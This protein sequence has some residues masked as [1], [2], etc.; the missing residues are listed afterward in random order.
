MALGGCDDQKR[1]PCVKELI[2]LPSAL[3]VLDSVIIAFVRAISRSCSI[4]LFWR[5]ACQA[6]KCTQYF[7]IHKSEVHAAA[8][9]LQQTWH[10]DITKQES[11]T[12]GAAWW[13]CMWFQENQLGSVQPRLESILSVVSCVNLDS[14]LHLPE[15]HSLLCEMGIV[16]LVLI[17]SHDHLGGCLQSMCVILGDHQPMQM[18]ATLRVLCNLG[19]GIQNANPPCHSSS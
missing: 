11:K 13:E 12:S 10:R 4:I 15:S 5:A 19:H 3:Q 14:S 18:D 9:V 8:H 2:K 7:H 17:L 6:M 1:M 16:I